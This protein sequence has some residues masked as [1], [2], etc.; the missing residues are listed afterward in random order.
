MK[1]IYSILML[2][3]VG[4]SAGFSQATYLTTPL[5]GGNSSS[6][7]TFNITAHQNVFILDVKGS[8][9]GSGTGEVWYSPTAISGPP[10]I[11]TAAG[12]TQIATGSVA[13][14]GIGTT[15]SVAPTNLF[16]PAGS[17]F[18]F[19][20]GGLNTPYTNG[21]AGAAANVT[22]G[23][24]TIE[25][26]ANVGYGGAA[27]N[28]TFH[29]RMFNGSIG[30]R[31]A[32]GGA[33]DA[34]TTDVFANAGCPGV[35]TVYARVANYGT[36]QIDSVWINWSKNGVLQTP[37]HYIGLLDTFGGVGANSAQI[38][39]GTNTF[40]GGITDTFDVWT[41]MPNGIADT[42]T[43]NDSNTVYLKPKL[44][45][46]IYTIG[47][48]NPDY[49]TFT[50]A[51]TDLNSI[52]VCGAVIFHVRQGTYT[53]QIDLGLIDG[54]S[55]VNTVTFRP[56]P[57]NT[58]AAILTYA[59]AASADNYVVKFDGAEY[60][61]FD[62]LTITATGATY[63]YAVQLA[64]A[65]YVTVKNCEINASA[66]ST[67]SLS[68]PLRNESGVNV[69]YCTI[70][71]N[72]LNNGYYGMYW[73]GGNTSSKEIGNVIRDNEIKNFTIYGMMCY[74]QAG[75]TVEGN[76]IEQSTSAT[77]TSYGLYVYYNDSAKIRGNEVILYGSGTNYGLYLAYN[78]GSAT[79]K[80][81]V[82]NNMISTS[83]TSTATTYGLYLNYGKH[84]NVY[85]NSVNCNGGSVTGGRAVYITGSTSTTYG[86]M[87]VRN[88]VFVNS[89]T[90]VALYALTGA[91]SG[92]LTHLDHNIYQSN[93]TNL[94]SLSGTNHTLA[95][96]T[97]ATSLDSNSINAL[98][99]FVTSTNLHLQGGVAADAGANVGVMTDID[100]QARPLLPSTGYDIGADEYI[101]PTCPMGYGLNVFNLTATSADVTWTAGSSDISWVFEYGAPGFTPGTGTSIFS[102][103]DTISIPGLTPVTNYDVYVRGICGAADT[104]LYFGPV[105]FKT[106][107]VSSLS[108]IYTINNTLPT[109]GVNYNSF[110]D[111]MNALNGCGISGATIF[112]VKQG[113]YTEQVN[114]GTIIGT[115]STS[116]ITFT[117]D[118]TNTTPAILTY[119]GTST[120]DNYV[121]Q[122]SG[123]ENII[124]DSLTINATGATYGYGFRFMTAD[125]CVVRNCNINCSNNSSSQAVPVY[126]QGAAANLTQ[127]CTIENNTIT[128]GY[129][130]LYWYGGSTALKELGNK[131][132]NNNISDYYL[133]GVMFYYQGGGIVEN[134]VIEQMPSA[135]TTSYGLYV[136]YND[137][138]K[139]R[140]NKVTLTGSGTNYGLYVAYNYGSPMN[141]VEVYN[142]MIVTSPSSTG[143]S[144][145]LYL[146]Y[147]K[148]IN[149]YH[150]SVNVLG[151]SSTGGRGFYCAGSTSTTYGNVNVRN[152]IFANAG[153]GDG[154]Y[155]LTGATTGFLDDMDYNIFSANGGNLISL[156]GTAHATVASYTAATGL[157]SNSLSGNP[158][159]LSA[160]DLHLQGAIAYDN[161]DP[162]VGVMVDIDGDTRPLAPSTG[163]DI[164]ADEYIPPTCPSPYSMNVTALTTTSAN[165]GWT[166]GPADSIWEIQYGA[167]G[168][169]LGTG[170]TINSATNP[171]AMTGLTPSTCYDVWLRSIC[172]VGDTSVWTGPFNFCTR[173][174]PVTDYCTSFDADALASTPFC[175][176]TFINTTSTGQIRTY[177]FNQNTGTQCLYMYN[178]ADASATMMIIAPEVSNLASGTHRANFWLRG[179]STVVV[180]TMSD[181]TNPGT[182]TPWDTIPPSMMNTG[183]YT[184][185]KVGFD[186]YTGTDTYVAFLWVPGATY[187]YVYMDDYCWETIPSC[188]KAPSV[189]I[190]NSGV[191]STSLNVGWNIDTTQVSYMIAYGPSGFDPITNPAGGDTTTSTTNFKTILGLQ[192]LTEYCV[193]VK[194]ICTNGDTSFWDGPHCGSTGCPSA[195]GLPYFEDFDTYTTAYPAGLPLCWQ[196]AKGVLGGGSTGIPISYVSSFWTPDGFANVGTTGAA[197]M[198]IYSTNRFEWI[199]SPS[200]NLGSDPNKTHIIEFDIAMTDY[201][202][203]GVGVVGYDDSLAFVVSYDD[204]LTWSQSNI[205]ESWDTS[206]VP[207]N[208]GDH[209]Y[210]ILRNKTGKVKFGFYATTTVSNEDNDWFIDNFS[211]KD[212]VF[213]GI[214]EI[215]LEDQ[216]MVFPNPNRGVFNV[217]N[218]G[219]AKNTSLKLMD[220]QGRLVYDNVQRFSNNETFEINAENLKSG[221]YILLIQSEVKLEQHRI[222][223]Q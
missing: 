186:T 127:N 117:A 46:G 220:V 96:W 70:E 12:W 156:N 148:H 71:N 105:T 177:N 88:N 124:F 132:L 206:N 16:I 165:L 68:V 41:T 2:F 205:I 211:I 215:T 38:A 85:H 204:G 164:G 196:E 61:I 57:A 168:F 125:N 65:K 28:P 53:E 172:T 113:T 84:I 149:I 87:D 144:Y 94:L 184:N 5:L 35:D 83:P 29:V 162:T 194:A 55:S 216:F 150:N 223:I 203:T 182:F 112:H 171:A 137:S 214:D 75:N 208:T 63:G 19:H 76:Y 62:S 139:I 145:G 1:K 7:C 44:P 191:D 135:P 60:V 167:P 15:T 52:G 195:T 155:I 24:I 30:Y 218:N 22:D 8:F 51:V 173:C 80:T 157:D 49:L 221:I 89:A 10:T 161:G 209:F 21:T 14:G 17:T 97:T 197:K 142:N 217:Q 45:G 199:V 56:D 178:S 153:P 48:V 160:T 200:I 20:V 143:T 129:Y 130:G 166:N 91:T 77:S 202:N 108:G 116:T 43:N 73:Y 6:G 176:N 192:P 47:G 13:G 134:N 93:G 174:A 67:S 147:G 54:A 179:D 175:W 59:A 27:P 193:W 3:F 118:P 36:N 25:M 74:Y 207:S 33:N 183:A 82:I 151:G 103:T 138:A 90:G 122:F 37:V 69:E 42:V 18:G 123:A 210:H 133:Y 126:N 219:S 152:N 58:S 26:G 187:D 136:Y 120:T 189:V 40:V 11:S 198:N 131:V 4:L 213:V 185:F 81:E 170:T 158:G 34:A 106:R 99:G 32:A 190:L 141:K 154:M 78:Y 79:N 181:P 121:V 163:W 64:S 119:A 98:P 159:F 169:T 212:T 222:V 100:G 188:E 31:I 101:P 146:A 107:C 140:S 114:I 201:A 72:K 66:I 102:A 111:A 180:G 104:S 115:S 110:A 86:E 92:F 50:D 23:S 39:L 95:T 128:K 109:A 9:T